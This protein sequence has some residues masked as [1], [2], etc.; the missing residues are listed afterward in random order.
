VAA[1]DGVCG[2]AGL[3]QI[4]AV[5]LAAYAQFVLH[6]VLLALQTDRRPFHEASAPSDTAVAAE[7]CVPGPA[8]LKLGT[9]WWSVDNL[10]GTVV[11][12]E[13][14]SDI[15]EWVVE[16]VLTPGPVHCWDYG[17]CLS[18][19]MSTMGVTWMLAVPPVA[20]T[21]LHGDVTLLAAITRLHEDITF[22][23]AQSAPALLV[24]RTIWLPGAKLTVNSSAEVSI[25][26]AAISQVKAVLVAEAGAFA[27]L[28]VHF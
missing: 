18:S 4:D 10:V 14:A 6:G 2:P 8:D 20:R 23:C 3:L 16:F 13:V 5:S 27:R 21:R 7:A 24:A 22:A 26:F 19:F 12:E 17:C 9:V 25:V 15:L 1:G 28:F 11:V